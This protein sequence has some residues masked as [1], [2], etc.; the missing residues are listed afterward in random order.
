MFK[1]SFATFFFLLTLLVAVF[2][3]DSTTTAM[4]DEVKSEETHLR[5]EQA[6]NNER[7]LWYKRNSPSMSSM[8][9]MSNPKPKPYYNR[10]APVKRP[11]WHY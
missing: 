4:A 3:Q 5:G 1:P 7:D 8:S 11:V 9:S 10:P 6:G 2:V